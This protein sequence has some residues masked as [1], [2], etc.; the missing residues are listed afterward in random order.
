MNVL[1]KYIFEAFEYSINDNLKKLNSYEEVYKYIE[2]CVILL[3]D[4]GSDTRLHKIPTNVI[5][6]NYLQDIKKINIDEFRE[7]LSLNNIKSII[8]YCCHVSFI[9]EYIRDNILFNELLEYYYFSHIYFYKHV[10]IKCLKIYI[11]DMKHNNYLQELK[12]KM[13]FFLVKINGK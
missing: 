11:H 7:S 5:F 10:L 13:H 3:E 1:N 9:K 8:Q 12:Q 6:V 4:F 2:E